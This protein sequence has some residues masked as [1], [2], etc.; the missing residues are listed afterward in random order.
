[1]IDIIETVYRGASKGRGLVVSPKGI[2][3]S[4]LHQVHDTD[5]L[6]LKTTQLGI[7]TDRPI[8]TMDQV[9]VIYFEYALPTAH[10]KC[11]IYNLVT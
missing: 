8:Q 9:M 2:L 7:D 10:S 6:F 4:R 3:L 5:Y 1:M 11:I